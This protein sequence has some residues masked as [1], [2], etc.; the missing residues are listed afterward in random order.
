LSSLQKNSFRAILSGSYTPHDLREFVQLCYLLARPHI[1]KKVRLGKLNLSILGITE[2]DAVHNCLADVFRRDAK[3]RFVEIET[4]FLR[5]AGNPATASAE[6][7]RADRSKSSR[8]WNRNTQ[9]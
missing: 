9:T 8:S 2:D 6:Q 1:S 5:E 3:G 4:F 7:L